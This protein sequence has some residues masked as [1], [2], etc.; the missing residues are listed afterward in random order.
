MPSIEELSQYNTFLPLLI[1]IVVGIFIVYMIILCG[2]SIFNVR[3]SSPVLVSKPDSTMT[4]KV[5][6]ATKLPLSQVNDGLSW[7]LIHWLYVDDWNYRFGQKKMVVNW[8]NNLQM[9]FNDQNNDLVLEIKISPFKNGFVLLW[10]W[11]IANWTF[12][13]MANWCRAFSWNTCRPT[14]KRS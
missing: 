7:T 3:K 14:R 1:K 10:C 4:Q 13:W 5:I 2:M 8:G 6:S 11:T 9:Y 12:L